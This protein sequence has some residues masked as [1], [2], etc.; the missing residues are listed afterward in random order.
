M[1]F[2]HV[3][4]AMITPFNQSGNIDYKQ[5]AALIEHLIANGSDGLVVNGTTGES[6]VLSHEEKL[7][8]FEYA[9]KIADRRIPII[10]GTGSNN[11]AE[12]IALTKQVTE[13]GA[14]GIMLVAPY[15]N[16]PNQAGLYAHFK[17]VAEATALPVMIYNIPGRCGVHIEADTIIRLSRMENI[18]ALK[19]AS[20]NLEH[21]AMVI[22]GTDNDFSVYSGD[23]SMTLPMLS[24]GAAGVVSVASHIIGREMN[25]MTTSFLKGDIANARE[26]HLKYLPVMKG[27][28]MSPSPAPVKA[29]LK[30]QGFDAGS[31]RLPLTD[32]SMEELQLLKT[33]LEE[34]DIILK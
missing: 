25:E 26:I 29:A 17:A 1:H 20:G 23:D 19:E 11:T 9:I 4:T 8:L 15:Y 10:A 34:A 6:P 30:L 21:A 24:I 14:D 2:G 3:L 18:A 33:L 7:S 22:A 31:V 27:L 12:S 5:T 13:L 28:F 32:V 16:K